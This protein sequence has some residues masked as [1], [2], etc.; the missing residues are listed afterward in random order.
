MV[1][2][3]AYVCLHLRAKSVDNTPGMCTLAHIMHSWHYLEE[4]ENGWSEPSHRKLRISGLPRAQRERLPLPLPFGRWFRAGKTC[5][6]EYC[7]LRGGNLRSVQIILASFP[8]PALLLSGYVEREWTWCSFVMSFPT[9][10]TQHL[11]HVWMKKLALW[12]P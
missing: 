12:W 4:H 9:A 1:G 2:L 6:L 7:Q 8:Q 11:L 5:L 3:H 10:L